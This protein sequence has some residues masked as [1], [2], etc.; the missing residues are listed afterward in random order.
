MNKSELDQL[1]K[2]IDDAFIKNIIQ[3]FEKHEALKQ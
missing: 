3:D 1:S 2:D